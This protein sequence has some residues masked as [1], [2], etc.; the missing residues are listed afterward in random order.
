M[1]ISPG[2]N[3]NKSSRDASFL[4]FLSASLFPRLF[5]LP[6]FLSS[7][8]PFALEKKC[9]FR[10]WK[11]V[12]SRG[13]ASRRVPTAAVR[14][15]VAFFSLSLRNSTRLR[16][17]PSSENRPRFPNFRSTVFRFAD[18][19]FRS[20]GS[21]LNVE[22]FCS[23]FEIPMAEFFDGQISSFI[24]RACVYPNSKIGLPTI[25]FA[26]SLPLRARG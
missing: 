23:T 8:Q 6:R 5:P 25:R 10:V 22:I 4:L 1:D 17:F 24:P 20:R 12:K 19:T 3:L 7:F 9:E 26:G 21:T 11:V 16:E 18:Q 14:L 13:P 2:E 15:K